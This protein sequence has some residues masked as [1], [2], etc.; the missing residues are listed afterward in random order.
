MCIFRF[1]DA[2]RQSTGSLRLYSLPSRKKNKSERAAPLSFG[3]GDQFKTQRKKL[4]ADFKNME[5]E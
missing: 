1:T 5:Y 2:S 3:D 4:E